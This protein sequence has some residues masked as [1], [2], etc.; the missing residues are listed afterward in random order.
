MN[1]A[2][3]ANKAKELKGFFIFVD[4]DAKAIEPKLTAL[5]EKQSVND[6]ALAYLSKDN[7]AVEAYKINL[8]PEVKNT[9]IV[10]RHKVVTAKIVN[11]TADEKGLAELKT[12]MDSALNAP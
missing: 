9:V 8:A 11:L 10:Y 6:I 5:A 1:D 12:A 7:G 4:D 3:L 2:V